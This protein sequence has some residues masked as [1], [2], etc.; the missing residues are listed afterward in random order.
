MYVM[1]VLNLEAEQHLVKVGDGFYWMMLAVLEMSLV[2]LSAET[3]ELVFT[4]VDTL[5]MLALC[6][7]VCV[8]FSC[9]LTQRS[10]I[11]AQRNDC[12]L[13]HSFLGTVIVGLTRQSYIASE[14]DQ[15]RI[16]VEIIEGLVVQESVVI[17]SPGINGSATSGCPSYHTSYLF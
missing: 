16:C 1:Q 17:I 4:T 13:F 12:P 6:V 14:G 15:L 3:V 2:S 11:H 9:L 10:T 8:I 7:Q 5:R